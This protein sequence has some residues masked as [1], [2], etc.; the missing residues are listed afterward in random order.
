M[1]SR[2]SRMPQDERKVNY[3]NPTHRN[4]DGV[5]RGIYNMSSNIHGKIQLRQIKCPTC[6]KT[7]SVATKGDYPIVTCDSCLVKYGYYDEIIEKGKPC[8]RR[9]H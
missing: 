6:G 7:Y 4:A 5:V 3:A 2:R 1:P 9:T 8:Q